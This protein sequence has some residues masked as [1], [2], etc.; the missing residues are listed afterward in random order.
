MAMGY[1]GKAE[2][3]KERFIKNQ[4]N[5]AHAPL[6]YKTGD[7][8]R[9]DLNGNITFI[10]RKDSQVKIRGYRIELSEVEKNIETLLVW[11]KLLFVW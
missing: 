6:L 4:F 9:Y 10:G 2:L 7:L 3:T 1:L 8:V 5:E 11:I